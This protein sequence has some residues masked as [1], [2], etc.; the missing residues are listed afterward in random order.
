MPRRRRAGH[1]E[2]PKGSLMLGELPFVEEA[3]STHTEGE[4]WRYGGH[5]GE[6]RGGAENCAI[7]AE[8]CGQVDLLGKKGR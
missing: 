8:G 5:G 3:K 2:L 4:Y 7:A 1:I 6:E